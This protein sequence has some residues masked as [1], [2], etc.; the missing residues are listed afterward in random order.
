MQQRQ[1][2]LL[3]ADA[4]VVSH[5]RIDERRDLAEDFRSHQA[6]ADDHETE[7]LPLAL[8]VQLDVCALESLYDEI[9]QEDRIRQR[10]ERKGVLR[11]GDLFEIRHRPQGQDDVVVRNVVWFSLRLVRL[12]HLPVHV[13]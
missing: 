12:H 13:E 4:A 9:P 3:A 11:A 8:R 6:A 7:Q 2:D 10:L 1:P 5:H